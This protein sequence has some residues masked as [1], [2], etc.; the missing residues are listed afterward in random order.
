MR[1]QIALEMSTERDAA[2][3]SSLQN[4][5]AAIFRLQFE[6][7]EIADKWRK[8]MQISLRLEML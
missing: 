2:E 4:T 5:T 1:E 7:E 8:I 6:S 3:Y